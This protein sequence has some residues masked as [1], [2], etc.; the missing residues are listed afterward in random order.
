[1]MWAMGLWALVHIAVSGR[2]ETLILAGG[3][4]VLALVGAKLQDGKKAAQLGAGWA[5]YA[6]KTSYWPLGAQLAGRLPWSKAWPGLLPIVAGAVLFV[7]MV[8]LHPIL[9]GKS[10]GIV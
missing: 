8:F 9:I 6:S 7:L 10:T 2:L 5:A 3:I 1:M 4:A